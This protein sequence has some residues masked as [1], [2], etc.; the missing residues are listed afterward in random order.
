MNLRTA[1]STSILSLLSGAALAAEP[2]A[3]RPAAATASPVAMVDALEGTF[4]KHAGLRRS[5]AKGVCAAGHFT[6]TAEGA[7]LSHAEIFSGAR[8]PAT[9]RFSGPGGNPKVSDKGKTVR[10]LAIRLQAPTDGAFDTVMISAPVF[11]VSRPEHFAG[12]IES[13][14]PDPKTGMPDPQRVAAFNAAHPD[15]APQ[16]EYLRA[17]PVPASFATTPYFGVH[18]FRF[19]DGDGEGRWVKWSFEPVAGVQGLDDEALKS[20]PDQFLVDELRKRVADGPVSFDMVVQLGQSDD[21]LDD[22]TKAWPATRERVVVGRLVVDSV[23]ADA[24]G[25]CDPILF[26][27][28]ALPAGI[29]PSA[30]PIL[31][32]RPAAYAVSV[33][34]RQQG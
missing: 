5:H 18:A 34:R 30:D 21:V 29:E 9:L 16:I 7:A 33:A 8:I 31:H 19:V 6:G 10:G 3:P 2:D 12:F 23:S 25:A 1:I 15:T 20:K 14:K 17:T 22:A 27:P 13:R 4:G 24:G 11:F 28:L 32:A 26:N